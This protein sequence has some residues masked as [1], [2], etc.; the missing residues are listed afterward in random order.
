MTVTFQAAVVASALLVRSSA[1]PA[2]PGGSAASAGGLGFAALT[3]WLLD[4]GSGGYMLGTWIAR[5]GL[6]EQRVTG[7]RLAPPLVLGH[8][9]LATAGLLV[10]ISYLATGLPALAWVAVG[11]LMLV[12]GLGISTVTLWT[13]F[14]APR[15]G[16]GSA[17]PGADAFSAPARE[18]ITDDMLTRA[19]TDEVLLS[20]LIDDVVTRA[21]AESAPAG[22]RSGGP[23]TALIPAGHGLAAIATFLLAVLTA[24][25]AR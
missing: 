11:L 21:P 9:G 6:R 1:A 25:G 23:M 24:I 13:P 17:G 15:A 20:K 5:G 8:F 2:A 12:I 7:D 14:P 18:V 16:P 10:W 19:L 22:R 4:A 3:T